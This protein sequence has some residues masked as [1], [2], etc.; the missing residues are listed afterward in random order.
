MG[1]HFD[2]LQKAKCDTFARLFTAL[3]DDEAFREV[4]EEVGLGGLNHNNGDEGT[5]S[6]SSSKFEELVRHKR[7]EVV[8]LKVQRM[9]P[10]A[11]EQWVGSVG[12]ADHLQ[13]FVTARCHSFEVLFAVLDNDHNTN[14]NTTN[15]N[16]NRDGV[17]ELRRLEDVMSEVGI[18]QG[19]QQRQFRS[20]VVKKRDALCGFIGA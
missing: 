20:L 10:Q 18:A 15:R 11:F 6:S 1:H 12:Y 17:G 7:N 2:A 5:T 9:P 16:G 3:S 14:T 13:S 19:R 4:V 8:K